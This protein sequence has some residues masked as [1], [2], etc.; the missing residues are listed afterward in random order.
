MRNISDVF[1]SVKEDVEKYK[2]KDIVLNEK[3]QE[4]EIQAKRV[5]GQV[6]SSMIGTRQAEPPGGGQ[7]KLVSSI[8]SP[9]DTERRFKLI[10]ISKTKLR[11]LRTKVTHQH[12]L[13]GMNLIER[14]SREGI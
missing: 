7:R 6:A 14:E 13:G 5:S 4:M 1:E 11:I 9:V 12:V 8:A 3:L 2:A 10:L